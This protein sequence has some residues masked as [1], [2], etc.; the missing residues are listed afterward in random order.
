MAGYCRFSNN[1]INEFF[2]Q[3]DRDQIDHGFCIR[4]AFNF[5]ISNNF[6]MILGAGY[7]SGNSKKEVLITGENSPDP[8]ATVENEYKISSIPISIGTGYHH[9]FHSLIVRINVV[10]EYHFSKITYRFPAVSELDV[11]EYSEELNDNR[12]G[13]LFNAGLVWPLHSRF[14]L[15]GNVGYR[16]LKLSDFS[17]DNQ[18]FPTNFSLDLSGLLLEVGLFFNI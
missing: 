12:L 5:P 1:E 4:G 17:T 18:F 14:S 10:A 3:L 2:Q 11:P 7:L 16:D 15:L 9:P 8:I 6:S 13:L